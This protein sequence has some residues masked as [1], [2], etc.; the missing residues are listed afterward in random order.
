[1]TPEELFK[2]I[3]AHCY[4]APAF[5]LRPGMLNA[6][7]IDQL[8]INYFGSG[9][10]SFSSVKAPLL[11]DNIVYVENGRFASGW[12]KVNDW[13]VQLKFSI[14]ENSVPV[15][16]MNVQLPGRNYQLASSFDSLTEQPAGILFI[17]DTV[18]TTRSDTPAPVLFLP[19]QE[20]YTGRLYQTDDDASL[21]SPLAISGTV[22]LPESM[23]WMETWFPAGMRKLDGVLQLKGEDRDS[24]RF[25]LSSPEYEIAL[26][27]YFKISMQVQ[28]IGL[29]L[30][31]A[32]PPGG[33][34]SST[35]IRFLAKLKYQA[36]EGETISIPVECLFE[37]A[38]PHLLFFEAQTGPAVSYALKQ[39]SSLLGGINIS[40]FLPEGISITDLVTLKK[41][42]MQLNIA[43]RKIEF[44]SVEF[45]L[46]DEHKPFPLIPGIASVSKLLL[47]FSVADPLGQKQACLELGGALS[48]DNAII[49]GPVEAA[50][51]LPAGDFSIGLG[52]GSSINLTELWKQLLPQI[53]L[54]VENLECNELSLE[55]DFRAR[56]FGLAASVS[57]SDG[58]DL[59]FLKVKNL[60]FRF[61]Y[62]NGAGNAAS[63]L[64]S[65]TASI[66]EK[67]ELRVSAAYRDKGFHF[68][69]SLAQL[70]GKELKLSDLLPLAEKLPKDLAETKIKKI[71]LEF[72]TNPAKLKFVLDSETVIHLGDA[73]KVQL[74]G[75]TITVEKPG[76]GYS[77][78][79]E[80]SGKV[81]LIPLEGHE[82]GLIDLSGKVEIKGSTEEF[83]LVITEDGTGKGIT[84]PL[85]IPAKITDGK[86]EFSEAQFQPKE[87]SFVWK[88]STW[89]I[90]SSFV[91]KITKT[92]EVLKKILPANG[93]KVKL[94]V[95]NTE[96]T[97]SLED[98]IFDYTFPDFIL[99]APNEQ[100]PPLNL[101]KSRFTIGDVALKLA[102]KKKFSLSAEISAGYYLPQR[103]NHVFGT[104]TENGV[105]KPKL[106]IFESYDPEKSTT[107]IAFTFKAGYIDG[108]IKAGVSLSKFP[109]KNMIS[110][111]EKEWLINLGPIDPVDK[112]G[113][114]GCIRILKP[115]FNFDSVKGG[116]NASGGWNIEKKLAIPLDFV[117]TILNNAKMHDLARRLPPV[118]PIPHKIE[119]FK[120]N[121]FN[122]Q[123]VNEFFL[124]A[125]PKELL[126]AMAMIAN[127]TVDKFPNAVKPYFTF[128]I[129][130]GLKFDIVITATASASID[131]SVPDGH[132]GIRMLFIQPV[133]APFVLGMT[134]RK[135]SF[136]QVFGGLAFRLKID[137]EFDMF[138]IVSL[139]ASMIADKS[140]Y[141]FIGD[142][143]RYH[144]TL[145]LNDLVVLVFY[146]ASG[147]PVPVP[148][149]FQKV[150]VDYYGIGGTTF[151]S[152]FEFPEPDLS[153]LGPMLVN[154]VRFFTDEKFPMPEEGSV[155]PTIRFVI[156]ENYFQ[157]DLLKIGPVGIKDPIVPVDLYRFVASAMNTA[158]FFD[159]NSFIRSIP[160]DMRIGKAKVNL[161]FICINLA[162]KAAWVLCTPYEFLR[163]G[164]VANDFLDKNETPDIF[165][166][167][168]P[169]DR[170]QP[171]GINDKGIVLFAKG[172]WST[173]Y[174]TL[175]TGFG[176]VALSPR[177]FGTGFFVEG[178]VA[179][180]FHIHAEAYIVLDP[181][182]RPFQAY[183][184]SK[185]YFNLI[186][187]KILEG[188]TMI[189]VR[190]GA[191]KTKQ[192]NIV[193]KFTLVELGDFFTIRSTENM[194]G[195]F[196]GEQLHLRGGV[197]MIV[198]GFLR[199]EISGEIGSRGI[200]LKDGTMKISVLKKDEHT[201]V[202][203][204]KIPFGITPLSLYAQI[205]NPPSGKAHLITRFESSLAGL[206]T[207]KGSASAYL[208]EGP[209]TST[210]TINLFILEFLNPK[211]VLSG[212]ARIGSILSFTGIFDLLGN[213][214]LNIK[215]RATLN[216]AVNGVTGQ[217]KAG[218]WLLNIEF[219]AG[220]VELN[221]KGL[222]FYTSDRSFDLQA[223]VCKGIFF[224]IGAVTILGR[225]AAGYIKDGKL[226][227]GDP[228]EC[229]SKAPVRK[230]KE[231][232]FI[233]YTRLIIQMTRKL[234]S[235]GRT[236]KNGLLLNSKM[237]EN[238]YHLTIR[239]EEKKS[240]A[241]TNVL[242]MA[243]LLR[244]GSTNRGN[245]LFTE[246]LNYIDK[247][248][249]EKYTLHIPPVKGAF[250]DVQHSSAA[251]NYRFEFHFPGAKKDQPAQLTAL[252]HE[253]E[254]TEM[255]RLIA[256]DFMNQV[257][258]LKKQPKAKPAAKKKATG[259]KKVSKQ[260]TKK[261]AAAKKKIVAKKKTAKT[262][263][264]TKAVKKK[265][266]TVSKAPKKKTSIKPAK[267]KK[268]NAPKKTRK[269]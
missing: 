73:G 112:M 80:T 118:L 122:P 191:N 160:A 74:N 255:Q 10:I 269:R 212:T 109:L 26:P 94:T 203:D 261:K 209:P 104:Y 232:Y 55:G 256:A 85:L 217:G 61:D 149:F 214:V 211:P 96:A 136:G 157:S 12:L 70:P 267:A 71:G 200:E 204:T 216:I 116:F 169:T 79:F 106:D 193:G 120:D 124:G 99:P 266:R 111:G 208:G 179:N 87:F 141:P 75:L 98:E 91:L 176:V 239:R 14:G 81:Q 115:D 40:A 246:L 198:L 77:Y 13:E 171:V 4:N 62:G 43:S 197:Q 19:Y 133:P 156:G 143:A 63:L 8:L 231:V 29:W 42:S 84:V 207:L 67:I 181:P 59:Y 159:I 44:I 16:E 161:N 47:R 229:R 107:P 89:E 125:L 251:K 268:K 7:A 178:V 226:C 134:L 114:Y 213:N 237:M 21:S 139:A 187:L 34:W 253:N 105:T 252:V 123:A 188:E 92:W 102:Y 238:T 22:A 228:E 174:G 241:K 195:E 135:F 121:K 242:T 144:S 32:Q 201:I 140:W 60:A 227:F 33:V 151:K 233:H 175:K 51:Q 235:A 24:P 202:I 234:Q 173:N 50:L 189:D 263:Q 153:K 100:L 41:I 184:K 248:T 240:G 146:Q 205:H 1:M 222:F 11:K 5:V 185:T 265:V 54:P 257:A 152:W 162:A 48:F 23:S 68:S 88:K 76:T 259:K 258:N 6:P 28:T 182:A 164:G 172:E 155:A 57:S 53:Q 145:M 18:I 221:E 138:D 142:P 78:K 249:R 254:T 196:N 206:L 2:F 27:G 215:G 218:L 66:G 225:R 35:F 101:G 119:F 36:P 97:I 180:L 20:K 83:R 154:I 131:I 64:L 3:N 220:V 165:M 148:V 31:P 86:P 236:T 103:I 177:K 30:D 260:A 38:N 223:K 192:F 39:F 65:G 58:L 137:G 15:I 113:K 163:P 72:S 25:L 166:K 130:D 190:E 52:T 262:V 132:P 250:L 158:K 247:K 69:G 224:L 150:G 210:G 82:N 186:A 56:T 126:D 127:A 244:L 194:G 170:S 17:S 245:D 129:P 183:G 128:G 230:T 95:G 219:V 37:N 90:S 110:R 168:L 117:R 108:S 243:H 45:G 147:I 93:F 9:G 49:K 264:K 199:F 167:I 46:P